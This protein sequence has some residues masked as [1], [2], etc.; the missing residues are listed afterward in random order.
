MWSRVELLSLERNLMKEVAMSDLVRMSTT[1]SKEGIWTTNAFFWLTWSWTKYRSSSKCFV[2]LWRIGLAANKTALKL[3]QNTVGWIGHWMCSSARR[4]WIQDNSTSVAA[5][6]LN[7]AS[8]LDLL[9][10]LWFLLDHAIRFE[11]KST[12]NPDVDFLSSISI[13]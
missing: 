6:L 5:R 12:Q 10:T 2:L 8:T 3:S 4:D 11:P 1:C 13:P 7:S 9:T